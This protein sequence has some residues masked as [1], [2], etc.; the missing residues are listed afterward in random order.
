[1]T[2]LASLFT[3]Y[4]WKRIYKVELENGE[5]DLMA[6][7]TLLHAHLFHDFNSNNFMV[8]R[9][10]TKCQLRSSSSSPLESLPMSRITVDVPA[11]ALNSWSES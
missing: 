8:L 11:G 4:R 3:N 5:D 7:C 10:P 2:M 6:R 1:M 9:V